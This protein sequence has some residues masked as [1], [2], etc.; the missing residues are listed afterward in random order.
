VHLADEAF[1]WPPVTQA[2]AL[3]AFSAGEKPHTGCS[4]GCGRAFWSIVIGGARRRPLGIAEERTARDRLDSPR[5]NGVPQRPAIATFQAQE[6]RAASIRIGRRPTETGGDEPVGFARESVQQ[7][8]ERQSPGQ[9]R[10][11]PHRPAAGDGWHGRVNAQK[12][13]NR[14]NANGRGTMSRSRESGSV[15]FGSA[16]DARRKI[17]GAFETMPTTRGPPSRKR[18]RNCPAGAKLRRA[19][20][21]E[22]CRLA[23]HY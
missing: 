6:R 21:H 10:P 3:D 15:R 19:K 17:I 23:G 4:S 1:R 13:S 8:R 18:G 16:A 9:H 12:A 7:T 20:S 2:S 5:T 14:L 22:R 11:P